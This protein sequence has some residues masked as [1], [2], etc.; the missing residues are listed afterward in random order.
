VV[1]EKNFSH[2]AEGC[3]DTTFSARIKPSNPVVVCIPTAI[4]SWNS[5]KTDFMHPKVI[6]S[7]NEIDAALY[8]GDEFEIKEAI[9]YLQNYLDRWNRALE[10]NRWSILQRL[11]QKTA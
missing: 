6:Q 2:R 1:T 11:R 4:A 10:A 3:S 8:S 5:L 9:D 7:I